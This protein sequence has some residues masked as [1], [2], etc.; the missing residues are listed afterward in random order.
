MT[1]DI[2]HFEDVCKRFRRTV[3]ETLNYEY[4]QKN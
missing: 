1:F 4:K 2:R 3:I